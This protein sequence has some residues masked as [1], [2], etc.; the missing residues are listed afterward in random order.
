MAAV[1][2]AAFLEAIFKMNKDQ[3]EM[4]EGFKAKYTWEHARASTAISMIYE[5]LGIVDRY[6]PAGSDKEDASWVYAN[7]AGSFMNWL[8]KNQNSNIVV[9]LD[10]QS[11]FKQPQLKSAIAFDTRAELDRFV[12]LNKRWPIED[13]ATA[14]KFGLNVDK[15]FEVYKK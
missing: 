8:I 1:A 9:F 7:N 10:E 6:S 5:P 14:Y 15:L 12:E 13:H 3:L 2:E 4:L 11:G